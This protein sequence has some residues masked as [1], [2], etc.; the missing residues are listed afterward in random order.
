MLYAYITGKPTQDLIVQNFARGCNA[1]VLHIAHYKRNGL[2]KNITGAIFAGVLRG[3]AELMR[4]VQHKGIDYYFIDHAYMKGGV[5]VPPYWMRVTKNGFVQN[6]LQTVVDKKRYIRNFKQDFA[7][8]RYQENKKI[9]VLPPTYAIQYALNARSWTHKA[10]SSLKSRIA[11]TNL[12]I[13]VMEKPDQPIIDMSTGL[14]KGRTPKRKDNVN[15]DKLLNQSYCVVAFNSKLALDA[16]RKGIPVITTKF[17]PAYP[18]SNTMNDILHLH[19]WS[20]EPLFE[21]LSM[22]QFTLYEM[23]NGYAFTQLQQMN[24]VDDER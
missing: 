22:G 24:Q 23:R 14:T 5:Y 10:V 20:R 15:W 21:S 8:W 7:S 13:E 4:E 1:Q 11:H 17:C 2:P 3:C 18:L 12:E 16:L 6:R 19:T 9:I